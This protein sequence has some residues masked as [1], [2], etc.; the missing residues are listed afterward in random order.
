MIECPN[1]QQNKDFG[2][3][4]CIIGGRTRFQITMIP[5]ILLQ[6]TVILTLFFMKP[7]F[8]SQRRGLITEYPAKLMKLPITAPKIDKYGIG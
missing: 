7:L 6:F 2:G 1:V 3:C 8:L 5:L 4:N